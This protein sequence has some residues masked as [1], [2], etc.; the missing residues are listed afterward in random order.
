MKNVK[1][2]LMLIVSIFIIS[3]ESTTVQDIQ[4]VVTNPTYN[5][6]IKSIFTAKCTSCHSSSGSQYPALGNYDQVRDAVENGSVLCRIQNQ[7]GEVM[8]PE[9]KMQQTFIDMVGNWKDQGYV[10]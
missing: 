10:Q 4:P 3:C 5:A 1:I 2:V 9:G 6:N 8:P 7:C